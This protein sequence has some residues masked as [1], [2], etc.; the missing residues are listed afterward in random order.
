MIFIFVALFSQKLVLAIAKNR[1]KEFLLILFALQSYKINY[2]Y[3]SK[4]ILLSVH[5]IFIQVCVGIV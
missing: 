2:S 4:L 1:Q 5:K 3:P